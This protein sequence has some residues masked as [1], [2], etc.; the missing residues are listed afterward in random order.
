MPVSPILTAELVG[1]NPDRA[2]SEMKASG[3]SGKQRKS[4]APWEWRDSASEANISSANSLRETETMRWTWEL[5]MP[6]RARAQARTGEYPARV[7]PGRTDFPSPVR[8][9]ESRRIWRVLHSLPQIWTFR[10][11]LRILYKK[12]RILRGWMNSSQDQSGCFWLRRTG[13]LLLESLWSI[14]IESFSPV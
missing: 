11:V 9:W 10:S 1:M 12:V 13:W 4:E 6:P 3:E 2:T 14:V 5:I 8:D 7:F